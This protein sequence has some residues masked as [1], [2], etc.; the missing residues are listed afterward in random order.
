MADANELNMACFRVV[1]QLEGLEFVSPEAAPL[2]RRLLRVA[3]RVI[4]DAAG[5]DASAE[6]WA[7]AEEMALLWLDEALKPLGYEV[8]PIEGG[9][10][11][12]L[13]D[14]SVDWH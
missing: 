13:P 3:G 11:P 2:V 1:E 6:H 8:R 9:G 7:G 5:E 12:E 10:K 4:I 14:P